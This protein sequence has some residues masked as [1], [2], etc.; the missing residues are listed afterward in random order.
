MKDESRHP[1]LRKS[2]NTNEGEEEK[3]RR[4]ASL[5]NIQI[6]I[7]QKGMSTGQ[8]RASLINKQIQIQ[9]KEISAGRGQESLVNKQMQIQQ[10]EISTGWM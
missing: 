5:V 10:K 1:V 2:K 3:A 7:P 8:R 6:Q 9:Q 4:Q